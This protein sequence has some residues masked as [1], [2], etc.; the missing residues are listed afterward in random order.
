MEKGFKARPAKIAGEAGLV[1]LATLSAL[2]LAIIAVGGAPGRSSHEAVMMNLRAIDASHAAVQRDVLRAR[3]GLLLSYDPLVESVVSLRR[4]AALLQ[5]MLTPFDFG[6]DGSL[7]QLLDDLQQAINADEALVE[8]F[9]TRNAL[10][11]NSIGVFGQTLTALHQ[12]PRPDVKA[13]L[14]EVGDLGNLMM[15]FSTQADRDG[16]AAIRTRLQRLMQSA[17]VYPALQDIHTL[18]THAR[19]ILAILPLVDAKV[20]AVQASGTPAR[21]ETLQGFYLDKAG[22]LSARDA[23]SRM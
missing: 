18:T 2:F 21:A 23:T 7:E 16:E 14:A 1:G 17:A 3:A 20:A 4:T 22:Q 11:Q 8:Q 15:R 12:S 13:V 5:D 6:L 9:K 19:M 10:L